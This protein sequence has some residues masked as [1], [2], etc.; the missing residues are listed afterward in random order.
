MAITLMDATCPPSTQFAA[1]NAITAPKE[2]L[3]YYDYG[4]EEL[5]GYADRLY[6]YFMEVSKE[7]GV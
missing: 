5:P 3:L 1:F 2:A 4:H 6:R 7:E